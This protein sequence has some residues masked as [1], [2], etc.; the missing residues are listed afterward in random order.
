MDIEAIMAGCS[1]VLASRN[2]INLSYAIA[3]EHILWDERDVSGSSELGTFYES[4]SEEDSL[5][6]FHGPQPLMQL[7][8]GN[9]Q[10]QQDIMFCGANATN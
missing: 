1:L 3:D 4:G 10:T 5:L 8:C 9:K 2:D 6:E 7:L